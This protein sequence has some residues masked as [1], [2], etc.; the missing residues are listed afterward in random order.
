MLI[1][2]TIAKAPM[3]ISSRAGK[4]LSEGSETIAQASRSQA[5]SK[6]LAPTMWGEDIVQSSRKRLAVQQA[7][8]GNW[9]VTEKGCWEWTGGRSHD[10]G[11]MRVYE[12]WGSTPVYVHRVSY[13]L[14]KGP[15]PDGQ[16]V[17]HTCDNP[18]CCNPEH[19]FL[20]DQLANLG[21]M[22]AKD[23]SAFGE[24]NGQSRL[25]EGDIEEI[26]ALKAAG[27]KQMDIAKKFGISDP[28]VSDIVRGRR[29]RRGRG[30]TTTQH[31]NFKH[32][33]YAVRR[34]D[35]DLV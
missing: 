30:K 11:E 3:P 29:W 10:Y 9:K 20:G 1:E 18:P 2:T 12:V 22:A 6:P 16:N 26:R 8:D 31:G 7:F 14:H 4:Q 32:G 15:I 19:L 25:T 35:S 33:K 13:V 23:R 24:R 34:E 27:W 17:C 5:G 21:D 28:H